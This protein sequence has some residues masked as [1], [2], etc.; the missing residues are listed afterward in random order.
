MH[1][2]ELHHRPMATQITQLFNSVL[3]R[4]KDISLGLT[5]CI[6]AYVSVFNKCVCMLL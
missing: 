5:L 2:D 4:M 6:C 3:R 1:N